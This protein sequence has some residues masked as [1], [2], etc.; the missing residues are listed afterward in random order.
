[1][2]ILDA[3][4]V[5]KANAVRIAGRSNAIVGEGD[6]ITAANTDS[7]YNVFGDS[8]YTY[9]CAFSNGRIPYLYN[10]GHGGYKSADLVPLLQSEVISKLPG[11]GFAIIAWGR[12]DDRTLANTVASDKAAVAKLLAA[13]I[14]PV[15]TTL[16][17]VGLVALDTPASPTGVAA[18]TGGTLATGTYTYT[19]VAK[20]GAGSGGATLPSAI[21]AAVSVTGPTGS[22]VLRWSYQR[23][24]SGYDVYRDNQKIGS[25]ANPYSLTFTDTGQAGGAAAPSSNT[26][27]SVPVA[28]DRIF[29]AQ[30]NAWRKRYCA[31]NGFTLIDFHTLLVDSATGYYKQGCS[32]DG[33]HPTPFAQKLMGYQAWLQMSERSISTY[34]YVANDNADPLNLYS[35]G[36]FL[37]SSGGRPT[38]WPAPSAG[39][40][41]A[42][43][44]V[45][46]FK[47]NAFTVTRTDPA[48]ATYLGTFTVSSGFS[49]GDVVQFSCV[50]SLTG[51]ESTGLVAEFGCLFSGTAPSAFV[52][53]WKLQADIADPTD[54]IS[55]EMVVPAGTTNLRLHIFAYGGTGVFNAGQ[56]TLR[57]LTTGG[58]LT[59]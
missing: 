50:A 21:G 19:V 1:M 28:D 45:A 12:N 15:F 34:G 5:T 38:G 6:S 35:N 4:G 48:G 47:G 13:G 29:T 8:W 32:A 24:V 36:L 26:T 40:T 17:P 43:G 56:F 59:T 23:G 10:A 31:A 22:V 2:G 39:T 54:F 37:T 9:M 49:V 58:T 16:P 7:I 55:P 3:P 20:N 30:V 27:G 25:T 53:D 52:A 18:T 46:G 33:T 44:A 41:L 42:V 51:A 14:T 11:N 57:N